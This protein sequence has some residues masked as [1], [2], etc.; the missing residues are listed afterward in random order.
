MFK[1]ALVTPIMIGDKTIKRIKLC[2]VQHKLRDI[3]IIA[4]HMALIGSEKSES[5]NT[6]SLNSKNKIIPCCI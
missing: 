6:S 2:E 1:L 5:F 4:L 3:F